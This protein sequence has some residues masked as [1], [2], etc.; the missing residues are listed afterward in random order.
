MLTSIFKNLLTSLVITLATFSMALAQEAVDKAGADEHYEKALI[1]FE[2]DDIKSA[3]IHLKNTFKADNNH[4]PGRILYAQML[5]AFNSGQAAMA[6]LE[7]AKT[8]GADLDLLL[9]FQVEALLHQQAFEKAITLAA[10]GNRKPETELALAYL[11]GQA[12]LGLGKLIFADENFDQVL[13]TSPNHSLARLGKAQVAIARKQYPQAATYLDEILESYDIPESTRILRARLYLVAKEPQQAL[14]LLNEAISKNPDLLAARLTRAQILLSSDNVETAE[15]DINYLLD[16][17]P[18]EPQTNFLKS[19]VDR[20]KGSNEL[21]EQTYDNTLSTLTTISKEIREENPQYLFLSG[22]LQF[23]KQQYSAALESLRKYTIKVTD[24]RATLLIAQIHFIQQNYASAE[25]ILA[26]AKIEFPNHKD[27]LI[28]LGKTHLQLGNYNEAQKHFL[29]S[30]E[31]DNTNHHILLDLAES[32]IKSNQYKNAH[33][34]LQRVGEYFPT[35]PRLLLLLNDNFNA[36]RQ[37]EDALATTETLI[38]FH[39]DVAQF[40]YLHGMN[41]FKLQQFALAKNAFTHAI[42]IDSSH[43]DSHVALSRTD[44]NQGNVDTAISNLA[45][46]LDSYPD[47]SAIMLELARIHRFKGDSEKELLWLTKTLSID[48]SNID[49]LTLLTKNYREQGDLSKAQSVLESTL[50]RTNSNDVRKLLAN[51]Y[52]ERRQYKQAIE[53]FTVYADQA[54]QRGK[55]LLLLANSHLLANNHAEAIATVEKAL[56]WDKNL[57]EGRVMLIKLLLAAKDT[58]RAQDNIKL[59]AKDT[60]KQA[61]TAMLTGDLHFVEQEYH[62]AKSQ[63]QK[64]FDIA[65]NES[66]LH[67]LYRTFKKLNQIQEAEDLLTQWTTQHGTTR[68]LTTLIALADIY[69]LNNKPRQ[70]IELYEGALEQYPNAVP[71]LNNLANAT[72]EQGNVEDALTLATRAIQLAPNNVTVLDTLAWVN[73]HMKEYDAALRMLR[74]AN[75]LDS[76]NL[77][78][79]Y[80]LAATLYRL[81]RPEAAKKYLIDVLNSPVEFAYRDQA[82]TLIKQL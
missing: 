56:I 19:L 82:E 13:S 57:I 9:P 30:L 54:K 17:A 55:A 26:R 5:L 22:Y 3:V 47:H 21:V 75:T 50:K 6:E 1:S 35:L 64:A 46:L 2:S 67:S 74:K 70:A 48:A 11:R 73:Y 4:L 72:L 20:Q 29:A 7:H 39:R 8:L 81:N 32:F 24:V 31:I 34:A 51:V 61:L 69:Q 42:A 45:N 25:N 63:Y 66:A 10:P 43:I 60:N 62:L 76:G 58:K 77:T 80:H 27:I 18:K 68:N 52:L 78:V 14:L 59:L 40:H 16:R 38:S 79:K 15:V 33:V 71:L 23:R 36:L 65:P 41:L 12:Y 37:I 49:A 28:L 53:L 44:V